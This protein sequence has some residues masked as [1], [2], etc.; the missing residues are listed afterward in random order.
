MR[1]A[2]FNCE[3]L[4]AR[5]K[6]KSNFDPS[7]ADGFTINDLAFD[8]YDETEK[9]ITAQAIREV[10]ADV[11]AL[12]E[13]ESLPVLD[14]F[15]SKYL[16]GMRYRHNVLIDSHDPRGIDVALLSRYPIT[17]IRSYRQERNKNNTGLLFSRDCLEC[18]L[19]IDGKELVIF[20]NHFKSMIGG[21]NET[22]AKRV[23]QAKRVAKI[24]SDRWESVSYQGN[25]VVLGD[26]ND[27]PESNTSLDSLLTHHGLVNI[28]DRLAEDE[29][30][31]HF[32][33]SGNQYHQLD[34]LLLS[35][36]LANSNPSA[37]EVMRKGLPYRAERYTGDRFPNVGEDNPKASDHAPLF[38]DIELI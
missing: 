34:Y 6:F 1:L 33:A 10:N 7:G 35:P 2:T 21:R 24:I 28:V 5:Y 30:W 32:Y 16:G 19:D 31:T 14:R 37:P 12:Q 25:Y 26:F 36:S 20:I 11:I 15:N 22:K 17:N 29:R 9:Q 8:I 4:F 18:H 13:I 23:E 38:M 3:N 27:Y